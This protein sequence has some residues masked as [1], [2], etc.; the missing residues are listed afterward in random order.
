MSFMTS[1]C[2]QEDASTTTCTYTQDNPLWQDS[3]TLVLGLAIIISIM[4]TQLMRY[5]FYR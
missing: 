3:A 2:V 1:E 4:V 5:V